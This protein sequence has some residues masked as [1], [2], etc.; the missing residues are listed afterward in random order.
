MPRTRL[1]KKVDPVSPGLKKKSVTKR[2]SQNDSTKAT[3]A[4]VNKTG[5]KVKDGADGIDS[6]CNQH[7]EAK[8]KKTEMTPS[9]SKTANATRPKLAKTGKGN[10]QPIDTDC[11]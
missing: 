10:K 5:S 8:K 9:N 2:H 7:P 1:Q 3:V 6:P 4:I 11:G